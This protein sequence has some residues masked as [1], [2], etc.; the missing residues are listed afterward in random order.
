MEVKYK[1]T[2]EEYSRLFVTSD[3]H[4]GHNQ[5]FIY[6]KRGFSS[7]QE[8]NDSMIQKI[9]EV[10]G[11]GGILLH[12]GDFCLNTSYEE[13]LN[14]LR[15]LQIKE[16]W[17]LWGNHNNPIRKSYGGTVEQ[18]SAFSGGIFIKYL[19]HYFTFRHGKKI[20]VCFHFPISV[21]DGMGKDA[22]HLCGHSHGNFLPSTPRDTTHK[23]LDCGWCVHEKPLSMKEVER[24]MSKKGTNN[25][26][27]S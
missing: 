3:T 19:D 11:P 18:I 17:L 5:E 24:I 20:F 23:I 2:D 4:F 9:N 13:Y 16:L 1:M 7:P 12:L 22:M 25:L 26:H 8:M 21:W 6:K 27:H 10:V 14:I 15:R